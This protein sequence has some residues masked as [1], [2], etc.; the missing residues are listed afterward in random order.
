MGWTMIHKYE[1]PC[2]CADL[3]AAF[4]AGEI[5]ENDVAQCDDCKQVWE[6]WLRPAGGMQWD[7]YPAELQLRHY[8]SPVKG[9]NWR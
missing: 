3:K 6:A 4:Q 2:D 9:N 1:K 5:E 7:P 8:K